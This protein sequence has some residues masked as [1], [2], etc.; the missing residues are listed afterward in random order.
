VRVE[1][2]RRYRPL[3]R[4]H[5]AGQEWPP[6]QS[7]SH[8]GGLLREAERPLYIS[9]RVLDMLHDSREPVL[10]S[11]VASRF[12]GPNSVELG[13]GR[14]LMELSVLAVPFRMGSDAMDVLYATV[15]RDCA[16]AEWLNLYALAGEVY[17]QG[18]MLW[19]AR[20]HAQEN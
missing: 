15:P 1:G 3:S 11:N 4:V 20:R 13:S 2:R 14:E 10:A 12:E 18:E 19:A 17:K 16:N 5:R 8:N 9:R 6:A 7:T